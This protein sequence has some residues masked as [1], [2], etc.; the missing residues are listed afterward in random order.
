[1][2]STFVSEAIASALNDEDTAGTFPTSTLHVEEGAPAL[3]TQATS[4]AEGA[5]A[6]SAAQSPS[7]ALPNTRG[8]EARP[9]ASQQPSAAAPDVAAL[10]MRSR[11]NEAQALTSLDGLGAFRVIETR[12]L[13]CTN[14]DYQ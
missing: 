9:P 5:A 6:A 13:R 14:F 10:K 3:R 8:T 4:V 1:M 12:I 2:V 11:A 7:P